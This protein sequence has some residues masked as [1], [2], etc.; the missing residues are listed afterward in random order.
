MRRSWV[1]R[2]LSY[3]TLALGAGVSLLGS[4]EFAHASRLNV[5]TLNLHGYH[6]MGFEERILQTRDG[7]KAV[8]DSYLTY[9]QF[10]DLREGHERQLQYLANSFSQL[11]EGDKPDVLLL[12]EVGAGLP[13]SAKDCA[14]FYAKPQGDFFGKN[15]SLRLQSHL[16]WAGE[17]YQAELAC[18]GN[19]GWRTDHATFAK[20]RVLTK[21]GRV[22]FDFDANPYANGFIVEGTA[23]LVRAP[24]RILEQRVD[25]LPIEGT[26]EN[27][28]LQFARI[29]KQGES[30]WFLVANLHG[31]HKVRHF[32]AAL[33]A[34]AHLTS[35]LSTHPDRANLR[36]AIVGGDFNANLYRPNPRLNRRSTERLT[37]VSTVP[38]EV[39]S[40]G[41][42]DFSNANDA[43]FANL[44]ETLWRQN[45]DARFKPWATVG[46][47]PA[48]RE[49]VHSA[50]QRFKSVALS[51]PQIQ[52]RETFDGLTG[53]QCL[54]L[55]SLTSSCSRKDRIDL[56]FASPE[57][58]PIAGA[59]IF[60]QNNFQSLEGPTDHPGVYVRYETQD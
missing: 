29:Q 21:S 46:S 20:S 60:S 24:Y 56:I 53:S 33:A 47:D 19:I 38:W 4:A 8:A 49:R 52:L 7:K 26:N 31:T 32:E 22:V 6:P 43:A 35:F 44:E 27:T 41:Q 59:I 25:W 34:R 57:L 3:V 48:A 15:S 54:S 14:E 50:V 16:A 13:N 40:P 9:F 28:F 1:T 2:L 30:S 36:G 58:T 5:V 45:I 55:K 11:S 51:S 10:E 42:F 23:I 12:Q 17:N 37:E 18:R 39:A